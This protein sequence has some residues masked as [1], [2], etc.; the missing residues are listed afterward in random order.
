[1]RSSLALSLGGHMRV[2]LS[3]TLETIR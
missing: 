2:R 1:V 3:L